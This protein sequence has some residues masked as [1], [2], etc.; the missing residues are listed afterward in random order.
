MPGLSRL[1]GRASRFCLDVG[2]VPMY[3]AVHMHALLTT[4]VLMHECI[5]M[6]RGTPGNQMTKIC[7]QKE[8]KNK[9]ARSAPCLDD[10][11]NLVVTG[12]FFER[13]YGE[14]RFGEWSGSFIIIIDKARNGGSCF[15]LVAR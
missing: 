15:C 10:P 8:C 2:K 1:E 12:S 4:Y 3:S 13:L 14:R 11:F 7:P 9:L 6:L 5:C